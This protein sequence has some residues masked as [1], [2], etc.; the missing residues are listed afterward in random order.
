[1]LRKLA[2]KFPDISHRSFHVA[3]LDRIL[4]GCLYA[5]G[6]DKLKPVMWTTHKCESKSICTPFQSKKAFSVFL[7]SGVLDFAVTL[8]I[9]M[10]AWLSMRT[11]KVASPV[12]LTIC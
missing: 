2:W 9:L 6:Q 12:Y 1:M 5:L 4:E 10:L 8:C 7:V 11:N 3:G